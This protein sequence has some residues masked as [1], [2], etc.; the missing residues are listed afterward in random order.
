M[1]RAA[2]TLKV[3]QVEGVAR[4]GV[5]IP[6]SVLGDCCRKEQDWCPEMESPRGNI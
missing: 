3:P 2:R 6:P 4:Y 1:N 5:H